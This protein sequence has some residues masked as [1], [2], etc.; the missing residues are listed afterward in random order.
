MRFLILTTALMLLAQPT[1]EKVETFPKTDTSTGA[2]A[3][4]DFRREWY[5]EHL[6]AMSEPALMAGPGETYRFLWL[7]S[8]HHPIAIRL[9]CTNGT[10]QLAAVRTGGKGGYEPVWSP[11]TSGP[12]AAFRE[13]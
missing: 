9:S 8:F 5:T 10:C 7:R 13:L 3:I 4:D 1:T 6:A 12:G 2:P 11:K